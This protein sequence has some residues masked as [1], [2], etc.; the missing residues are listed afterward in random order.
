MQ[1]RSARR[2]LFNLWCFEALRK[3]FRACGAQC[4]T[5]PMNVV[6]FPWTFAA[7][8]HE[9]TLMDRGTRQR[10]ESWCFVGGK[11]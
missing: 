5:I 10:S 9:K 3:G 6:E 4:P 11:P 8:V 2:C 7:R 1:P